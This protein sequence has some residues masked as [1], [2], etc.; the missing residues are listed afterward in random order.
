MECPCGSG[1]K[2]KRCCG[3]KIV[4]KLEGL[5]P[6]IRMKGGVGYNDTKNAYVAIVHT[7]DNIECIGEPQE[8]ESSDTFP[9]ENEAMEYYK[10]HIRLSLEKM[11]LDQ[12]NRYPEIETTHKKLE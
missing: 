8:W 5:K 9:T 11:M 4:S 1:K 6:G 10:T 2:Y 7:W 3:A 12:K